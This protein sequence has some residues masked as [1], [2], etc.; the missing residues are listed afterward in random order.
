MKAHRRK[1]SDQQVIEVCARLKAGE[2]E[3][4]LAREF[5]VY[6]YYPSVLA[7]GGRWGHLARS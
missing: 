3:A 1:L 4:E 2:S 5:G 6:R 7:R